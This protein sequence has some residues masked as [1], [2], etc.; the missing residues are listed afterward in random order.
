MKLDISLVKIPEMICIESAIATFANYRSRNYEMMYLDALKFSFDYEE[1][2]RTGNV[3]NNI[4]AFLD[5]EETLKNAY[6]FH[7]ISGKQ[8]NKKNYI[9]VLKDEI[10]KNNRPVVFIIDLKYLEGAQPDSGNY[11]LITGYDENYCYCYNIHSS[12]ES[13]T[14][15][16]HKVIQ[17]AQAKGGLQYITFDDAG[18]EE[19][20]ISLET[21]LDYLRTSNISNYQRVYEQMIQYADSVRTI[22]DLNKEAEVDEN[23]YYVPIFLNTIDV[24]RARKLFAGMFSYLFSIT[25]DKRADVLAYHFSTIGRNWRKI[26]AKMQKLLFK[27]VSKESSQYRET[28]DNVAKMIEDVAEY[29]RYIVEKM[30]NSEFDFDD[31]GI[32]Q[33]KSWKNEKDYRIEEVPVSDLYNNRSFS[34][35]VDNIE[36]ADISG[37]KEYFVLSESN[38]IKCDVLGKKISIPIVFGV[39]DN[40]SCGGNTINVKLK[41]TKGLIFIGCA[42]WQDS[43]DEIEVEN[44][45][46]KI[47]LVFEVMDWY[48]YKGSIHCAWSGDAID[49]LGNLSTRGIYSFVYEFPTEMN[50]NTIVLPDNPNVHIYKIFSVN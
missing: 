16:S 11:F 22:L 27:H 20:N 28:V 25:N 1:A 32:R 26:W 14:T 41:K 47:K 29:E 23:F 38:E 42:E 39:D 13:I 6:K 30:Y 31:I 48:N 9:E 35:S 17:K 36:N 40:I 8:G 43:V 46:Q 19:K 10:D 24:L 44:D 12:D 34:K 50:I 2:K 18:S 33:L 37:H 45:D 49:H 5:Q 3:G 7:G 4:N 15:L 21:V